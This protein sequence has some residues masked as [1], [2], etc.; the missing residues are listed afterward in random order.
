LAGSPWA[1]SPPFSAPVGSRPPCCAGGGG[2]YTIFQAGCS[3]LLLL[4]GIG[5]VVA[6]LL[7]KR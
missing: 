1:C 7:I 2:L 3:G 5:L 6:A 4:G